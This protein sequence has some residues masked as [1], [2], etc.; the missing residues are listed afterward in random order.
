MIKSNHK[1]YFDR[2]KLIDKI[3]FNTFKEFIN[4]FTK[5]LKIKILIEGNFTKLQAQ[6]INDIILRNLACEN[7]SKSNA[8]IQRTQTHKIP[9][10]E[11]FLKVKSLL[12]ND[13][14]SVVKN[15]YQIDSAS[16]EAQCLLELLVKTIREPI[17]NKL[18]TKE[19]LGYSVSCASKNDND[20]L[21]FSV[22]IEC[23]EKKNS[24]RLVDAKI[25]DFLWEFL[26]ILETMNE[27]E[28]EIVK[29]SIINQKHAV[30]IDLES[31][32]VRN[33]NEIRE[34]KYQFD[35]CEIEARQIELLNKNSLII[36]FKEFV[37]SSSRRKL[38]IH[39]LANAGDDDTLLQHGYIHLN[40]VCNNDD[41]Q[42]TIRNLL[43]FKQTL[44]IFHSRDFKI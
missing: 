23:Q 25:E 44:E 8:G 17:F 39:L 27:N 20:T 5:N 35:R 41:S 9:C 37:L 15:Y 7:K 14:N 13:K 31:E 22:L 21:G 26:S 29:R 4:N 6:A 38:S 40:L 18:R 16:V 42:N 34:R 24:A 30:D 28:F 33:W 43:H 19:Q 3:D 2:F 10:G 1:F 32:V 11:T 12:P 36:F